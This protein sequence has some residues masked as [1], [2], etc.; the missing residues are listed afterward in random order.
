MAPSCPTDPHEIAFAAVNAAFGSLG[1]VC[2]ALDRQFRVRHASDRLDALLGAGAATRLRGEPIESVLGPDL[3]GEGGPLRQALLA[4]ERREGWRALLRTSKES[5][6]LSVTAVPL[7]H[8]PHGVCDGDAV[9]LVVLRPSE[10]DPLQSVGP[11]AGAGV[12]YR[13]E[14]MARVFR[15][16]QTL[17]HGDATVL[18]SGESG[19]GKEVLARMI[20]SHSPRRNGPF[21]AV[22]AAAL[23]DELLESELFGHA[24]GAF[25]GAVRDRAGRFE[26]AQDGTLFLDEVGDVPLH[27]QVKLLR[28]LQEH[29]YERVGDDEPRRTNARIIAA[30][31]RDLRRAVAAGT[32]RED[33]YYRLRVFPVELPPLRARREDIE[34]IARVLLSR[35]GSR[36]GRELRFSP[37]ALRALL[38][39]DWPGNVRELENALEYAA[40]VCRGQTLQPEDLPPEVLGIAPHPEPP[41]A[42]PRFP[43]APAA[44]EGAVDE[45]A[46]LQAAL[47][48]HRWSRAETAQA[49]GMSRSTLWRRMR[50]LGLE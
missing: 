44:G 42:E 46:A 6:L 28:V 36:T 4:G 1:R 14:A 20:H 5:R 27:L 47:A 38:S 26:S 48:A 10:E 9:Y 15:L 34:P 11:L 37:D 22:N 43:L 39:H 16:V 30:T 18:I 49:L 35:T 24:R 33:L 13:S 8:D 29:T 21:V 17:Q 23:P 3:F 41:R 50:A 40:T 45:R 32:F 31:H 19:T 12:A 7:Q 25:T 2:L